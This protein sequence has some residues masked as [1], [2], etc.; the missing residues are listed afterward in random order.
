M[1]REGE[2]GMRGKS[3]GERRSA[4]IRRAH[5]GRASCQE[6]QPRDSLETPECHLRLKDEGTT[7]HARMTLLEGAGGLEGEVPRMR[8][9]GATGRWDPGM[10]GKETRKVGGVRGLRGVHEGVAEEGHKRKGGGG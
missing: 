5:P 9:V 7:W 1:P 10:K 4:C 3:G 8:R 6:W 2:G